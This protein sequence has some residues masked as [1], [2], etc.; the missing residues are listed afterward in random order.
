MSTLLLARPETLW[1]SPSLRPAPEPVGDTPGE[2]RLTSRTLY[3]FVLALEIN[4]WAF[5]AADFRDEYG[6]PLDD[7][8]NAALERQ[9]RALLRSRDRSSSIAIFDF[10]PYALIS[11]R[12][13]S[14]ERKMVA[15]D[16]TGRIDVRGSLE[17]AQALLPD[18][19]L[20]MIDTFDVGRS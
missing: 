2:F 16:R 11:V 3:N 6:Q 5:H 13:L 18:L 4:G 12:V 14:P 15:I 20:A 7:E 8:E 9:M 19:R 10:G 1:E 17:D